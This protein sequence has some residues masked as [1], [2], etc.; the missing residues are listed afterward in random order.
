MAG[1]TKIELDENKIITYYNDGM[2]YKEMAKKE[3]VSESKIQRVITKLKKQGKIGNRDNTKYNPN[4]KINLDVENIVSLF[5]NGQSHKKIAEKKCVSEKTIRENIKEWF[6]IH[7]TID[8][9][10]KI[11]EKNRNSA[12]NTSRANLPKDELINMKNNGMSNRAIG[13]HFG[14]AHST[15]AKELERIKEGVYDS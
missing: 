5:R 2:L 7:S 6:K 8:E 3:N 10:N 12:L 15:I 4:P 13:K 9:Y 11:V 1:N 14:V